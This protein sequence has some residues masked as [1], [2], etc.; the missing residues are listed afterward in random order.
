MPLATV[1]EQFLEGYRDAVFQKDVEAFCRL[2]AEDVVVFD[3]WGG[4]WFTEGLGAL[5]EGA[6]QWFRSLGEE[7]VAVAASEVHT[8]AGESIAVAHGLW[9]FAAMSPEGAELRWLENRFTVM[10]RLQAGGWKVF[11]QHTSSPAEFGSGKVQL[12]RPSAA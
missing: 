8:A 7:R 2:Y 10:L 12:Q 11:H 4:P 3:A 6:E 9:R 5:R 1:T